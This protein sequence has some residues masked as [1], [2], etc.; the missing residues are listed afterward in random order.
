MN[1]KYEFGNNLLERNT[2][3]SPTTLEMKDE[4]KSINVDVISVL[5]I[6]KSMVAILVPIDEIYKVFDNIILMTSTRTPITSQNK[7]FHGSYMV[8]LFIYKHENMK[9]DNK[10]L[11]NDE[12]LEKVKKCKPN[13]CNEG[14]TSNHFASKGFIAAWGN[15]ALYGKSSPE[16]SVGQYVAK[17]STILSKDKE[18]K[19]YHNQLENMIAAEIE[20]ATNKI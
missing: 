10:L 12:L 3:I 16:L 5:E 9:D 6:N 18:L 19:K 17:S 4:Q 20:I 14:G 11:W 2:N 13:I 15:N 1:N 8:L 7:Y